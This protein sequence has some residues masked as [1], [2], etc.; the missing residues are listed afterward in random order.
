MLHAIL[1]APWNQIYDVL[2]DGNPPMALRILA[3]NTVFFILFVVRR[4]RGIASMPQKTAITVQSLL[5]FSNMLILF[6]D[7]VQHFLGRF[8]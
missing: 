2:A 7:E 5:V 4:A 3:V 1:N 8:I 6:Q